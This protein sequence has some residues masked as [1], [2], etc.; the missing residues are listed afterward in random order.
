MA[1]MSYCRFQNTLGDLEDCVEHI[2]DEL[3]SEDEREARKDLI[4]LCLRIAGEYGE[5]AES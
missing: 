1:N 3:R 5:L 2:E 4:A